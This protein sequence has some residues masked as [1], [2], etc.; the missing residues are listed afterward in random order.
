MTIEAYFTSFPDASGDE[1]PGDH[2]GLGLTD[3]RC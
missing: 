2:V 3:L 1:R